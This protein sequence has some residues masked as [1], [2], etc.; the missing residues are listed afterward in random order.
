MKRKKSRTKDAR[1]QGFHDT[2]AQV[3]SYKL[4]LQAFEK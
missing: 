1:D 4:M 3:F 2:Y